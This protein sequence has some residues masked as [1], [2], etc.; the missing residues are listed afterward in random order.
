[1]FENLGEVTSGPTV[2]GEGLLTLRYASIKNECKDGNSV[3]RNW[4]TTIHFVC[5]RGALVC[6]VLSRRC[7][8][9]W[10]RVGVGVIGGWD[11]F[12]FSSMVFFLSVLFL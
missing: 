1:M 5:K 12:P 10:L 2:E 3:P 4:T 7:C 8:E 11:S 6:R 9:K